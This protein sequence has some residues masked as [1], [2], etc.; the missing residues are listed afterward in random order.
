MAPL[1]QQA[2]GSVQFSWGGLTVHAFSGFG[3]TSAPDNTL[4]MRTFN[5]ENAKDRILSCKVLIID[6]IS[7]ISARLFDL[8]DRLYRMVRSNDAPFGGIQL[9][10]VGDHFQ[11]APVKGPYDEGKYCFLSL[12]WQLVF[13]FS[14]CFILTKIFRQGDMEFIEL[15]E[16]VKKNRISGKSEKKLNEMTKPLFLPAG[17]YVPR[18]NPRVMESFIFNREKLH[19]NISVD[20]ITVIESIDSGNLSTYQ[21]DQLLPVKHKL[22]LK[23]GCPVM[24]LRNFDNQLKNRSPGFV[25][26]FIDNYP[27]IHFPK[28]NRVQYFS[29]AWRVLYVVNKNGKTGKRL[30]LPISLSYSFTIHKSQ[31]MALDAGELNVDRLFSPGH[32]YTGL[33]RFK[34]MDSVRL[35]NYDGKPF[36]IVSQEVLDYYEKLES[37]VATSQNSPICKS[38]PS[39]LGCC[40]SFRADS[41]DPGKTSKSVSIAP[42]SGTTENRENQNSQSTNSSDDEDDEDP[43]PHLNIL[44]YPLHGPFACDLTLTPVQSLNH[45][46]RTYLPSG[47]SPMVKDICSFIQEIYNSRNLLQMFSN[48]LRFIWQRVSDM[49][50]PC[51]F[52]SAN[53]VLTTVQADELYFSVQRLATNKSV[54]KI[55]TMFSYQLNVTKLEKR[56]IH[57]LL[58]RMI[59][60]VYKSILVPLAASKSKGIIDQ[61][62]KGSLTR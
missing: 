56:Y 6:E 14:H 55:W 53:Y 29:S 1:P 30:Q 20:E 15:L 60:I 5:N 37:C 45:L 43:V 33:S 19:E 23:E 54:E 9:I 24:C 52:N 4:I 28:V 39:V 35:L 48:F 27:V 10:C 32:G 58:Y 22:A 38:N 46:S 21:L 44:L 61:I 7:M 26:A 25:T 50:P 51:V 3:N 40:I 41:L 62:R 57:L 11:L 36:N 49:F 31:G 8:L 42:D 18:L 47:Q 59:K 16:E 2:Q 34:T 12:M 13:P 17:T